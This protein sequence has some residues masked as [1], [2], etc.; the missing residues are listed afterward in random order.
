MSG[1]AAAP[2]PGGGR[3][4][5]FLVIGATKAGSTSLHDH[6]RR[7]AE[8]FMHPRKELRFFNAEHRWGQGPDWYAAQFAAAGEARAVGEASNGYTRHPVYR[9]APERAAALLP[10]LRLVYLIREPWAR[11]ESHYRWRLST[12]YESR[13]AAVA[14]RRDPSYVAS[15]L[16]GMQLAEWRRRFPAD[17]ILV[18]RSE[19]LFADPAPHLARLAAHLGVAHDPA[20]P[21]RRQN[22]TEGRRVAAAP[23]RHLG[24]FPALRRRVKR[25]VRALERGPL[26]RLGAGAG[27]A[28]YRLPDDLRAE[29]A[30][31]LAEDRRRLIDLAGAEAADWGPEPAAFQPPLDAEAAPG[32]LGAALGLGGAGR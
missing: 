17:Q 2:R 20:L 29:I 13:P 30:A 27:A 7:H 12:G 6:L 25:A 21:F 28:D 32:R 31:L 10:R 4:P 23:L 16:Y 9:G 5:D 26:G 14:L 8:V 11:L 19:A 3:M 18:L 15:S 22:A 24:R 1:P